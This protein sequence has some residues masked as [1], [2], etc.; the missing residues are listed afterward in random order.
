MCQDS[1]YSRIFN[2]PFF[3]VP[4]LTHGLPIFVNITV[5]SMHW[6]AIMEWFWIF[7]D[8]KYA[9]FLH[10]Q[11]LHKVLNVPEYG[12]IIPEKTVLTIAK[13][14]MCLVKSFTGFWIASGSKCQC[15][16]YSKLLMQGLCRVP[17]WVWVCL[18]NI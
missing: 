7:K 5:L 17:K 9:R 12:W 10:T 15:S 1:G 8:S 3:S 18:K 14:W 2:M 13:L 16:E 4:L 11:T 6:D